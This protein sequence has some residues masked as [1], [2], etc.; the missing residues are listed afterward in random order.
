MFRLILLVVS[1]LLSLSLWASTLRLTHEMGF[2][3]A[4]S[5]DPISPT[6]FVLAN[7]MI[8]DRL[9]RLA[10]TGELEPQ[11]AIHWESNDPG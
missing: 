7:Q 3:G 5:L 9:V 4:E 2:R 1:C 8:Y 6:R 11:L 10:P